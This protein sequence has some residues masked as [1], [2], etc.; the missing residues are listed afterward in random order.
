MANSSFEPLFDRWASR[1]RR[2]LAL[3]HVLTGAAFG[4]LLAVI[5]AGIAWKLRHGSLRPYAALTVAGGVIAGA[6]IARRKRWT[7]ESVALYLD[8]E[9][10]AE[11]AISTA[12]EIE[13]A[14]PDSSDGHDPAMRAVVMQSAATALGEGDRKQARPT[15]LR[16]MHLLLPLGLAGVALITRAPLPPAPIMAVDPGTTKIQIAEI[17]GLEKVIK[18]AQLD[19]RDEAQ[20]QRLEKIAHDA[21]KLKE[22]LTKGMEKRDAQDKIARL[23]EQ[24]AAERLTLGD[25][26]HRQ[27]LESAVSKLEE[28]DQTK[29][30]AEA[31]GDH[32]LESMD[33]EME[34]LANSREKSDR[35][36]AK[37]SVQ[38]AA[39]AA[40]K[41]GAEDVAKALEDEKKSM[42][43]REKRAEALRDL[44]DA[45]KKEGLKDDGVENKSEALDRKGTDDAAK[46]LGDAMDKAMG[47][48]T[49]EEKKRLADR[50]R[51]EAKKGGG[52]S[53]A[54]DLKDMADQLSTPEGQKKLEDQLKDMAKEDD[55][56]DETK[57]QKG[58]DD[59]QNGADGA[60]KDI[61]KQKGQQGEGQDQQGQQQ[62]QQGQQQGQQGQ[63]QGQQGQQQGQQGQGQGQQGQGQGQQGQQGQGQ[64]Q[65]QGQQ[66]QGQ[67]LG[68]GQ[69]QGSGS[70]SGGD[71]T[72]SDQAGGSNG[73]D[74]GTG[75]HHGST[76]VIDGDTLKSR[77][78]G[79][80]NKA[81]GMPG[82]IT[83][84]AQG[85][86]G[87]TANVRGTGD[88][89]VVGPSEV[90]GVE[91]SDVPE[92]YRDQVRQYFQP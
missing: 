47:K 27:G 12:V 45:M 89:K 55:A 71:A 10:A 17:D 76:G 9:L 67:G 79:H 58:L 28:N 5:P 48:L 88:L 75:D 15:F 29:R 77:A 33:A 66:G 14:S 74:T 42:E 61:G 25:G 80:I 3:R 54:Q 11:E 59:A 83:T 44:A 84:T 22:E 69:Q 39:D 36:L 6:V 13:S 50:L 2:R 1:V 91:R 20:R 18:L 72:G 34:K 70:G 26:K 7:D 8:G 4:A 85:R 31:L 38:D 63:Q 62:G 51:D 87:G 16:P 57:R 68:L 46:K 24:I 52:Q 23:K 35:D 32:D 64:G 19:P 86:A 40:K 43:K 82:S 78:H 21:E 30:A 37:K 49:P 65:G 53:D 92:E 90:D 73:H 81:Q 60:E 56:T 41:E